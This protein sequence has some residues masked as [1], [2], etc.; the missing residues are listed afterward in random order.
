MGTKVT[1]MTFNMRMNARNDG[2]YQL[3]PYRIGY[4]IDFIRKSGVDV[5]GMQEVQPE[6]RRL[7]VD[8]LSADYLIAG[9]G[10]NDDF[11]G[12]ASCVAF[13]KDK[14]ALLSYDTFWI[15]DTPLVPASR[16]EGIHI[17][18]ICTEVTLLPTGIGETK[19]FRVYNTHLFNAVEDDM[20]TFGV[21][22][23][24][25]RM[26]ADSA[27]MKYP[28]ALMG[29]FNCTPESNAIATIRKCKELKLRDLTADVGYTFN[30]YERDEKHR[31][32]IDYIFTNA[33]TVPGSAAKVTDRR[34]KDGMFLSDHYPVK[35][36]IVL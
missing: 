35:A 3:Y 12:E 11:G 10:R 27:V 18:R 28:V 7:L 24:I 20:S 26:I 23:I 29:D 34:E 15:S 36:A 32:K 4:V 30:G 6:T 16:P 22:V 5:I 13:K 2:E 9:Y 19:P 17:P 33:R 25:E 1:L 21:K 8:S 14:F 31:A